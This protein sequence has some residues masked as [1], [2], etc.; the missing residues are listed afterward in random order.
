V[1]TEA[2]A[3]PEP[4]AAKRAFEAIMGLRK[5]DF[6]AIKQARRGEA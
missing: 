3:D 1:R 4:A 5:I 2:I 6:S